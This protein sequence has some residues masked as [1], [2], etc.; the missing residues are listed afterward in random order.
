MSESYQFTTPE[1]RVV[2][3][4]PMT[5]NGVTD[6]HGQPVMDPETGRQKLEYYFGFAIPKGSETDWKQTQWGQVV[7]QAAVDGWK[8]GEYNAPTFSWKI[9]D[10]DSQIPNKKGKKPAEREGWPGHWVLHLKTLFPVACFHVGKYDPL[11]QI[12]DKNEIKCGDYGRVFLF[13]KANYPSESPGVYLNPDK[14]ELTRAGQPIVSSSGPSAAEVFGGGAPAPQP[15]ATTQQPMTPP[16]TQQAAPA[17]QPQPQ[18]AP[19]TQPHTDFLNGPQ[20]TLPEMFEVNGNR[21][22]REQ[23]RG[24]GWSDQQIDQSATKV[25]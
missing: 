8:N 15:Q 17:P 4:H 20:P 18:V 21:Y 14:F 10:G 23:L 3:G 11:Q 25:Q 22:T 5:G 6:K 19:P 16:P 1:G 13:V 24:F 2:T 7:Q 9:D 12:Q